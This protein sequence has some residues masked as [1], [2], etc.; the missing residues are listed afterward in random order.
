MIR[1]SH[2]RAV[3][4]LPLL[5]AAVAAQATDQ[6][7]V[8]ANVMAQLKW[9]ELGP[10]MS[11][12]RV[13]DL[14]VHPTRPQVF[15]VAAASGGI[16]KTENGGLRFTPQF[17][18]GYTTS[19]G[20]LA[21]APS[22]G[23]V[24]YVGTGE[25]NNQRSS[26]WGDGVHKSTDGGKTWRHVGL[27]GTDHIGRVVVHPANADVCYVA[28]LG[29][30][31]SPNDQRGLYK[32]TDGGATWT[33]IHH[34][35][36]DVGF[37]DVALD[38]SEPDI[39]FAASYE[40]R[41]RAWNFTEGGQG[42]RLWKST[43]AGATWTQLAG[44]LP[45]GVLG[46]IGLDVASDGKTVYATIE[47]GNPH[48][49]KTAAAAESPKDGDASAHDLPEPDGELLADVVAAAEHERKVAQAQDP[50]RRA[51]RATVGGEVYRSDDG[52]ASWRRTHAANVRVGGDPGYYYGQIRI[53]PTD[54]ETVY[55]LSVPVHKSTD[56][57]KTWTPGRGRGGAAFHGNLHVDHHALWIDPKDGKHALLGN[58]GGVAVTWDGGATWDHLT[59][60]PIT[61]YY[62]IAVDD[63]PV[64]RIYGGLQD[65]GTWGFP[66]LGPTSGGL[67]ATDAVRIDGG[68]GFHVAIDPSDPDVVYSESQ[69]GGMS[70]QDLG[71]G[72]RKGIK[73]TARKG[74]QPLRFNWQTPLL[75]SPHAPHTVFTG[76]QFVH[77]SRDRG[78]TWQTISPD[79]TTNDADKKKGN[80]PHCT[81]TTIAESLRKEGQLWVGT[82]DGRVW[83]TKDGGERWIELTERFPAAV[84]GLWV[85]RVEASPHADG[86][87]FVAFTGYREDVRAPFLFRTD[88]AGDTWRA[89]ANDLPAE[90]VNVVRQ[91]PRNP[92]VLLVGTE[93]GAYASL[94]D[95]A[96][97]HPLGSGLPRVAVHDLAVQARMGH[98]VVGT[99]GR[100]VWA[101]DAKAL[102]ELT[103][104]KA[105]AA[106][107]V[108]PPSDGALLRRGF[109][110]GNTGARGWSTPNPFTAPTFRYVLGEDG[111]AKVAIE[112]LDAAG[113][114]LWRKDGPTTAGYHEVAWASERGQGF[115]FGGRT[116]GNSG[117]RAGQFAVRVTR[118]DQSRVQAFTV[119]DR[120]GP[121][122]GPGARG[123]EGEADDG[124]VERESEG[125]GR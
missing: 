74:D 90:P 82:D 36:P 87:A 97:W 116:G 103:A 84:K 10:V 4:L 29:A 64:Y 46:R 110:E 35:G 95:G 105:T 59:H 21:V 121:G 58:D 124:E 112:V 7:H 100:G 57:G 72:A 111:G 78:D 1:N 18:G 47:N 5:A 60:L 55:V 98:V 80:V 109:S 93:M 117:P 96:H 114:V 67:R 26:Y 92:G 102:D 62:A 113:S 119:H 19:I 91:H 56:G 9:Q 89:I 69:F 75:L 101:L 16:W 2:R 107:A 17:Q 54:K 63:R 39:V 104:D 25:A 6:E 49:D 51:R 24:L 28:A 118:G 45:D 37:V 120:R 11:G 88:D 99:H 79:L 23:D 31:Y 125:G 13:V 81:I 12:G 85:S 52:G 48:D 3:C 61:Q 41:R 14:A 32:T 108:L 8:R 70:R 83:L 44:G 40:R 66:S 71:T 30:L 123:D 33:R 73:P 22:N 34:L 94:D 68:D 38:P 15:W 76:S 65:N 42:S 115:G 43:D 27:Q 86:T 122:A 106:F 20:D 53:D 77:R 50:A